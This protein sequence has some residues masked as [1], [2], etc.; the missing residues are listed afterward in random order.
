[1][2]NGE[3]CGTIVK[4]NRPEY[5]LFLVPNINLQVR[6]IIIKCNLTKFKNQKV[7]RPNFF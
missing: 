1:M 3:F 2:L 4:V 7:L 6:S 5:S